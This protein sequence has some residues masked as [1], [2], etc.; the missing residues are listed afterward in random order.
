M[1]RAMSDADDPYA[2]YKYADEAEDL[3]VFGFPAYQD[4]PEPVLTITFAGEFDRRIFGDGNCDELAL[5]VF[6]RLGIPASMLM[7]ST[8]VFG[9]MSVDQVRELLESDP[10]FRYDAEFEAWMTDPEA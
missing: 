3:I 10:G 9:P 8:F 5:P 6:E 4:A 2:N 7:P 1:V